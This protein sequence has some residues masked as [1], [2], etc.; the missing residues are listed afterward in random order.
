M[1]TKQAH[2]EDAE[3][4]EESC[5]YKLVTLEQITTTLLRGAITTKKSAVNVCTLRRGFDLFK[6]NIL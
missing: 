1:S 6:D 2:C 5:K 3:K 4:E